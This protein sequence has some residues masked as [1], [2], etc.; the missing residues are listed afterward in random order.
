M[1]AVVLSQVCKA[2]TTVRAVDELTLAVPQG[3]IYGFIGPNGSGKTTTLRMIMRIFQ[4]DSGRIVVL[5]E[6]RHGPANDR[7][8]YLP[9]ERGLYR[10]MKIGELLRFYA[11]LK[12]YRVSSGEMMDW[13][14]RMGLADRVRDRVE[15]LSKGMS[16]KLQFITAVIA[17]PQLLL[18]D[19]PFSGLD[20][21]NAVVLRDA[22]LELRRSGA[23]VIFSTHDMGMAERL[24]D[25]IF[26]I[27]KGR[28]V[29]DGTLQQI[30]EAYGRDTVRV[31]L[32]HR[33]G[34]G[35]GAANAQAAAAR[36]TGSTDGQ[37]SAATGLLDALPG[38]EKVTDFGNYQELRIGRQVDTAALLAELMRRGT[39]AQFEVTPPSL[40]DIFV[41]IAAPQAD[42]T[43]G[44]A[45]HGEVVLA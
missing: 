6:D 29:L 28:K 42:E 38:V 22:V 31:R 9:E 3:S 16:Q 19:E 30:Q 32:M 27:Y 34:D 35:N 36:A 12:G 13:L 21:V 4:P 7:I 5:G 25:S 45:M 1:D 26:M 40:Q 43:P 33:N 41:R 44:S 23:T 39:V 17:R 15:T 8:G 20:P 10:K 24:C 14:G 11:T 37:I 18:L 2:F